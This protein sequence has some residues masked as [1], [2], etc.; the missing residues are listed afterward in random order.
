[1]TATVP[2]LD[3]NR[4]EEA[5]GGCGGSTAAG[6]SPSPHAEATII[7]DDDEDDSAE[8]SSSPRPPRAVCVKASSNAMRGTLVVRSSETIATSRTSI[9]GET[10]RD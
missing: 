3:L 8:E 7:R 10:P 5:R 4:A 2:P 9:P 6:K 1:M